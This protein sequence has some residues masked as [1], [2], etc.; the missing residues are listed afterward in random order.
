MRSVQLGRTTA[1]VAGLV[2]SLAMIPVV[3]GASNPR[4]FSVAEANPSNPPAPSEQPNRI[5]NNLALQLVAQGSD[6]GE[7]AQARAAELCGW[8]VQED[9]LFHRASRRRTA[10]PRAHG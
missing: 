10:V 6:L 8:P 2:G 5:G 3:R 4:I 9:R 1:L 7:P